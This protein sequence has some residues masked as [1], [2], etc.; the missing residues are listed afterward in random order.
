MDLLARASSNDSATTQL[1]LARLADEELA[2]RRARDEVV[3]V[4]PWSADGRIVADVRSHFDEEDLVIT[5]VDAEGIDP[6]SR[7]SSIIA[8][9]ENVVDG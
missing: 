2:V 4:D 6:R 3:H 7:D 8:D 5:E 9:A 1:R